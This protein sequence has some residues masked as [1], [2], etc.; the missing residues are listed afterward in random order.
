[1]ETQELAEEEK[2]MILDNAIE[3]QSSLSKIEFVTKANK[4]SFSNILNDISA[5]K[6]HQEDISHLSLVP[7][8]MDSLIQ[9]HAAPVDQEAQTPTLR[10]TSAALGEGGR[11]P[12]RTPLIGGRARDTKEA[13]AQHA[14]EQ[15]PV[16]FYLNQ[17]VNH[18]TNIRNE[19]MTKMG[20]LKE[21]NR[22]LEQMV[23]AYI[24]Q[25]HSYQDIISEQQKNYVD[26]RDNS[27]QSLDDSIA[28]LKKWLAQQLS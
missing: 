14:S 16:N 19:L 28:D 5:G 27:K 9:L 6:E 7:N 26:Y 20:S 8:E 24:S 21:E 25:V 2:S 15:I 17:L 3:H 4:S 13:Q 1:M 22:R 12:Y 11:E 18:C 10:K 23:T